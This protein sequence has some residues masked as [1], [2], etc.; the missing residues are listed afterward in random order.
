MVQSIYPIDL[1]IRLD[2]WVNRV[3][4][5]NCFIRYEDHSGKTWL[6]TI[7]CFFRRDVLNAHISEVTKL[8]Y[9]K[10][11]YLVQQKEKM[12]LPSFSPVVFVLYIQKNCL[13]KIWAVPERPMRFCTKSSLGRAGPDTFFSN[14]PKLII[15]F[16]IL[17]S[18]EGYKWSY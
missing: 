1:L 4:A 15:F 6:I 7:S 16:Y 5:P 11:L 2:L 17:W 9:N 8:K 13:E 3:L 18:V 12:E 14:N 10:I